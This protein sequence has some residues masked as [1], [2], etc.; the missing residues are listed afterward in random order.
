MTYVIAFKQPGINAIISDARGTWTEIGGRRYGDNNALKTG[1]LFPGCIYGVIGNAKHANELILGFKRSTGTER[2]LHILWERFQEV[3]RA[4]SFSERED[5][6]FKLLLSTRSSG[7]PAF[8][9]LDPTKTNRLI[10]I[11]TKAPYAIASLGSGKTSLD[12]FVAEKAQSTLEEIWRYL[13]CERKLPRRSVHEISPYFFCLWLS[14]LSLTTEKV[15]LESRFVG[16]PFHFLY[17][18]GEVESTQ[19][20]A[21]YIFSAADRKAKIVSSWWYRVAYARG[22]LYIECW[23]PPSRDSTHSGIEEYLLFSSAAS[24]GIQTLDTNTLYEQVKRDLN[25]QPFWFFCGLG[26]TYPR[27]RE[28]HFFNV[29]ADG[30]KEDLIGEDGQLT[31]DI[32]K[33][34][35]SGF[36][37]EK[38][39]WVSDIASPGKREK[40]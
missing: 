2:A 27:D 28:H 14:E 23:S 8:Y 13:A 12:K 18:T 5:D 17:Q 21:V 37:G 24:P 31:P 39:P 25:A 6:R 1:L 35:E 32:R 20:P 22:G 26:H 16:G 11:E 4:H 29:S 36:T 30:K 7:V 19:N 34:I 10:A 40:T 33:L 15:F 9:I 38:L 3:V